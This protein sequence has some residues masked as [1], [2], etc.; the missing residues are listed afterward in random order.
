MTDDLAVER[1]LPG[2]ELPEYHGRK[3]TGMKSSIT[4]T[5]NR[6]TSVH[7]I[8]DTV[9]A[10]VEIKTKKAGHEENETDGLLYA[11]AFKLKDLFE[12]PGPAGK[13]LLSTL[14]NTYRTG[15]DDASGRQ[16][17][18]GFAEPDHFGLEGVTDA[19][20]VA[21]TP[22]ELAEARQD[23][24]RALVDT[25]LGPV[26][27]VFSDGA[28]ELWP[29]EFPPGEVSPRAGDRFE[30]DDDAPPPGYVYVEK[31]LDAET[32]ETLEEWTDE[33]EA[34]RLARLEQVAAEAEADG[35]DPEAA[36]REAGG[37]MAET[38]DVVAEIDRKLAEADAA[39]DEVRREDL[40]IEAAERGL[41]G[42]DREDWIDK[43]LDAEQR[44]AELVLPTKADFVFV[45]R[46]VADVKTALVDVV[47][48][49][50]ALRILKAEEQGRG[51]GLK[52]R[53]GALDAI[54]RRLGE[55]PEPPIVEEPY[56]LEDLDPGVALGEEE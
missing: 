18:D 25:R 40:A 38:N 55:I 35:R 32:G 10:V 36:M 12:V 19:S 4:G 21:L 11:E 8:G 48:R 50:Q 5:S 20:G 17:I 42:R 33:Q 22:T 30:G 1:P 37:R 24:V 46:D 54:T 49:D 15:E 28:R 13:R 31:V 51:R 41:E 34:D 3:P 14:R 6:I 27:V 43:Q 9:V 7:E 39:K 29:D 47:D 16:A 56:E 2:L 44:D 52:P 26:V 53:K 23:P 45:D